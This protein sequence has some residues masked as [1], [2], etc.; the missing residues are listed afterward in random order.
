MVLR[1]LPFFFLVVDI[2]AYEPDF[3]DFHYRVEL[4]LKKDQ[5]IVETISDMI[6]ESQIMVAIKELRTFSQQQKTVTSMKA[7]KGRLSDDVEIIQKKAHIL[8]FYNA[9][10]RYDIIDRNPVKVKIHVDLGNKF[11]LKLDV[12]Y[13]NQDNEFNQ[14]NEEFLQ[15]NLR[16]FKA[17]I[18]EIKSFIGFAVKDLQ[19]NGFFKPEIIEKRVVLN[20]ETNEATLHLTINPGRKVFFASVEIKA[21][22]GITEDFI[23]NRITWQNGDLFDISK[24]ESTTEVLMS[25]QIFSETKITPQEKAISGDQI[26]M[27]IEVKEDKKHTIDVGL[28]YSSAN[29][30][31]FDK[32]SQTQ[33]KLK[34]I[35]ARFAWVNNNAFGGGEKLRFTVEGTPLRVK[36]KRTDYAFEAALFQPDV[37]LKNNTADYSIARR[38][39]LTNVFFRKN[40]QISARFS[41]PV[42]NYCVVRMGG[43]VETDYVDACEVFFRNTDMGKKYD[44]FSIPLELLVDRTDDWLNPTSGYRIISKFSEIFFKHSAIGTLKALDISCSYNHPL[45]DL[46]RTVMAFNLIR[47]SVFGQ[48]IDVIPVDQRIYAGGMNSIRGYAHQMATEMVIGEETPMGGK[49]SLEFN[50]EIRRRFTEN[51]GGVLFFDGA[52]VFQNRSRHAYLQTEKKRWFYAVGIGVRYFTS[53]GPIRADLAFPIKRRRGVD[54]RVQFVMSLGQAF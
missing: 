21:F 32:K 3:H 9:S 50:S 4:I 12:H 5:N 43:N 11:N 30:M 18:E 49:A 51:F 17:S 24:V 37:F 13:M 48:K 52:R 6:S 39:E 45:D 14:R 42:A 7:L 47:R 19:R 23:K 25:S 41:Y 27:S 26:P 35:I 8:G 33:K 29:S 40:D 20:H 31:N 15:K 46:K 36:E 54:S 22:P 34:S 38:Q 1:I 2:F 28:L 44:T 53:I 16:R 10:V